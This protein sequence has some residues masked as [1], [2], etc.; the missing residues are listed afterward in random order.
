MAVATYIVD[1]DGNQIDASTA[2]VPN[3]RDFRGAWS[4]SGNVI[5]EDLTKAKEIFKDKV[6]EVRNPKLTALDA[7]YMKALE[8]GDTAA[9]SAIA[10]V[11]QALRDA[12]A[13]SAIDAATDMA[14]LKAAWDASLLGDSPY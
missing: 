6:R 14:G 1:K 10:T 2:T 4:L 13:A 9:Q 7:D 11:K 3:N 8:D 12:P 5:N